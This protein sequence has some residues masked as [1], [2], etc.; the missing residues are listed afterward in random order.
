MKSLI[1][2]SVAIAALSGIGAIA[3][4][5]AHASAAEFYKCSLNEGASFKQL[6]EATAAFLKD[7]KKNGRDQYSVRFLVPLYA[8]DIG[9]NTFWWV[10]IGPSVGSVASEN[11]YWMSEANAAH[12][13]AVFAII[14]D[15]TSSSLHEII[16]VKVEE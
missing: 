10:G 13:K 16:D 8:G 9:G 7:A 3:T 2:L 1:R 15:C 11:D 12:R 4:Q 5:P 6:K 14:K